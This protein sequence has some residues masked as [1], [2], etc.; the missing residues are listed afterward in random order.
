MGL[1]LSLGIAQASNDLP[2]HLFGKGD[3]RAMD[4]WVDSVYTSLSTE[5]RLAQLI[6]PIIYPSAD[7][8]RI[9]SEEAR[10]R[11]HRWGGILYQR[12]LL[13]EQAQMDARL[14]RASRT[15]ML[16]ALDGEWGLYM[17][18]KDA[19]RY[20]RNMGLGLQ[21]DEQALYDY[22]REVARQCRLM[23]IHVN[24]AP[25]VDVNINPRNPVIGTRSF[26][27][28]P[29]TVARLSLAYAQGLEDGGVLSVA[30]HF[31]GH[32]DTSED[33]HKTLPLVSAD[34]RR[35]QSVE[36]HPFEQYIRGGFGGIMTAHLR[37]PA[38][39]PRPIPSSLS[40]RIITGL[41]QDEMRFG[42]LIFTDGLEMKGVH[43]T[44]M[45]DVGVAALRAGNDILLGPSNAEAQLSTLVSALGAGQLDPASIERKVRKVLAYKW[46]LIISEPDRRAP[47]SSVRQA[48]YTPE[49]TAQ[50][51]ALWRSSL[52][53][54]S[55]DSGIE[56]G[57]SS[58]R[59]KR[60]AVVQVGKAPA[61]LPERPTHGLGGSTI[62]Y[63]TWSAGVRL[64]SY[65][66]VLV[67]ALQPGALPTETLQRLSASRPV[68]IA[69]YTS[70]YRVGKLPSW[71][72]SCSHV[73]VAMEGAPEAQ[74]AVLSL[75]AGTSAYGRGTAPEPTTTRPDADDPTAEMT[76]EQTASTQLKP[77]TA[78]AR[79]MAHTAQI[80]RPRLA[81]IDEIVGE[82][83]RSGAFPGC[84]VYVMHRGQE[85]YSRAFGTMSGS[86][87][88]ER[89]TP[90]T[91][92]DAASVTKALAMTPALMLLVADG[93]LSLMASVSTY[94]PELRGTDVGRASIRS[95][96]LHQSGLPPGLNFY[97]DL[98]DTA[99][100]EGALI[101]SRAFAG[102]IP[103]GGNAYGNPHFKWLSTYISSHRTATHSLTMAEGLYITPAFRKRMI[104]RIGALHLRHPGQYRY[105]D[106]GFILLQQVAERIAGEPLDALLAR[107]IYKPI[108]AHVYF[109]PLQQGITRER[110]A[111]THDDR[112]LRK[113]VIRGTVDDESAACLGGVSGSAGL[114]GSASELAKIAQ[115][116]LSRGR[117]DGKEIIPARVV[118]LFMTTT[119]VGGRRALGFDK[120]TNK[121][122]SPA[123][124]SAS[125]RSVGHLGFTGT[126][127]WVDP[128]AELVFVFL[129]NRTYPTRLN[130]R[131]SS[132]RYR[133][134]LHQAVYDALP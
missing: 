32:G 98:I 105:S 116:L 133:P 30:K 50:M 97:T 26:G 118:D 7:E 122:T 104:E 84:Q 49:A 129:S 123:A 87:R 40:E 6:M 17:R 55:R 86:V 120:P 35:M 5:E 70:P 117:H 8:A 16:I 119:G 64:D 106:L 102:G 43:G 37:V 24:F 60:I 96:L 68:L 101:R 108:G 45:G 81:R 21:G 34:K 46:R 93:K 2:S 28:D 77:Q 92:Y 52:H 62:T 90:E 85:V 1:T 121:P 9:S 11:K 127:F 3:T 114:Y 100:Y 75:V 51:R 22:G 69:Y 111:P 4:R 56:K 128:D 13:A 124:E 95:L 126:A 15:P 38:Y 25:T 79:L 131:L 72:R 54:L 42:G 107:R 91:I 88:A 66:L 12:G 65:D 14:Q 59:Y 99:S 134:R 18:L 53:Y 80:N 41:L 39:E 112:F 29:K 48:I 31:P 103:L 109:N 47:A 44:E 27:E 58:G 89:V 125:I 76:P 63:I 36:L 10:V 94:L 82:G 57:I 78:T 19:P 83:I 130:N 73:I 33:S 132:E 23:G 113:Q 20:P 61:T 115:L 71:A 67:N 74:Q 110:I